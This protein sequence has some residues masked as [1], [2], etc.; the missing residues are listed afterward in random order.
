VV[1]GE[2]KLMRALAA[3]GIVAALVL[4]AHSSFSQPAPSANPNSE[5]ADTPSEAVVKKRAECRQAGTN[6]GLRGPDLVDH[7]VVC[8]QEARLACLKQ[9]VEQKIRGP[10]RVSFIDKCLGS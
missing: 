2:G 8:V 3:C 9:A 4:A 7:V 10:E 5:G 6:Q 1:V